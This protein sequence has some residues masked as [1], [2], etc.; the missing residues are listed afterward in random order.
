MK[1][2][3]VFIAVCYTT[4]SFAQTKT[5]DRII[6]G[7]ITTDSLLQPPYENWYKKNYSDYAVNNTIK[8]SFKT[9][10]QKGIKIEA[11]FGSWCGDSKRELPRFTKVLD[12][13]KFDKNNLHII[14]TG[15]SDSLYK[16][17][18]NGE[19]RGKGIFRVPV[20]IVYRN[21]TE[22]GR[23][24][25]YPVQTLERDLLSI[26]QNEH[27]IPNYKSFAII[28]RW[29]NQSV[30]LDSNVSVRGLSEQVK[31][32]VGNEHELNSLA[33]LLVKQNRKKEA[34]NIFRINANLYPQSANTLSSLGEG[35]LETGDHAKAIAFLE[36]SLEYNPS[37]ELI[38]ETLRLLYKAKEL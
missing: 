2:L 26:L 6:Y 32:M 1:Q 25:E 19:D 30:L 33:Y 22:I 16:Q 15:G 34:L 5:A 9:V 38:K 31:P 8:E 27:Y 28:T 12:E 11:F 29:L 20:F 24:N 13:I 37:P 18:P 36:K 10:P 23:I 21:G 4:L 3:F 7:S 35:Y 14:A 17:S